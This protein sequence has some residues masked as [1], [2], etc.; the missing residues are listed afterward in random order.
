MAEKVLTKRLMDTHVADPPASGR[1][2]IRD[3]TQP[4]LRVRV[5]PNGVATFSV[6]YRFEGVQRRAS[7]GKWPQTTIAI[8]RAAAK[9]V[10][11]EV[12]AGRDPR[13]KDA[14]TVRD[15]AILFDAH[16]Q[17]TL[18]NHHKVR[19]VIE[20]HVLPHI[21][22]KAIKDVRR[23]DVHPIL[24]ALV[25][26]GRYGAAR[27]VRKRLHRMLAWAANR[28]IIDAN[29]LHSME[30]DDLE[31]NKDAG[32][33]LTALE[34]K[35]IW[36]A[37]LEMGYPWGD[38]FRL[39]ILTGQRR[40]DWGRATW[41]EL[42]ADTLTISASRFK[43]RRDHIVPLSGVAQQIVN[44]LPKQAG[45]YLFSTMEGHVAVDGWSGAKRMLDTMSGVTGW[46]THDM[47][48]TVES[49]LAA[50]K[51]PMEIRGAVLGHARPGLQR[52]YQKYDW[53]EEKRAALD[54]WAAEVTS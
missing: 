52:L 9:K 11:E 16:C 5:T 35:K 54:M 8:A 27:E 34:L 33:E 37:C 42:D 44:G 13:R 18:V 46:R 47:R 4:G 43:S 49:G 1:L 10:L 20:M 40:A 31:S 19:R 53:A 32:R 26:K 22:N 41:Q 2:V 12:A 48:V 39:L 25:D 29:P 38:L 28:E 14:E 7:L 24:D 15:V 45:P 36:A 50:L 17:R 30:R 51:I 23:R 21:G 6:I 3:R